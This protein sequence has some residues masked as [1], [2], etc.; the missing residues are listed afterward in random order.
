MKKA[1]RRNRNAVTD[2]VRLSAKFS[3][4]V[5]CRTAKDNAVSVAG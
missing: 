4:P 5:I 3:L 2:R 1:L